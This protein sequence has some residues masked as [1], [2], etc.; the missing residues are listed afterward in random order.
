MLGAL[1]IFIV[2]WNIR[3]LWPAGILF[4]LIFAAASVAYGLVMR[5]N[6]LELLGESASYDVS[7]VSAAYGLTLLTHSIIFMFAFALSKVFS[8][9]RKSREIRKRS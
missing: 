6:N 7:T 5:S 9:F 4:L 3:K 2:G 1:I 8:R